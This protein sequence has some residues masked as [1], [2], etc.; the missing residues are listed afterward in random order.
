MMDWLLHGGAQPQMMLK[1]Q[2][3]WMRMQLIL[4]RI[5]NTGCLLFATAP[6]QETRL[7]WTSSSCTWSLKCAQATVLLLLWPIDICIPQ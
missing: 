7:V 2:H 1:H 6:I 4:L 3:V 5:S